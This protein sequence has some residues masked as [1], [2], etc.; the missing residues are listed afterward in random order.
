M[1]ATLLQTLSVLL[2]CFCFSNVSYSLAY[3]KPNTD[4][5]TKHK[6]EKDEKLICERSSI[7]QKI[8]WQDKEEGDN[9]TLSLLVVEN[10]IDNITNL[11]CSEIFDKLNFTVP[12][13]LRPVNKACTKVK[14]CNSY[15]CSNYVNLTATFNLKK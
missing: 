3:F 5:Q 15:G 9:L 4:D 1:K 10:N 11:N 13:T 14:K 8:D 7:S 6:E 12:T 2:V